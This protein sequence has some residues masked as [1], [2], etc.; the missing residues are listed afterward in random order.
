MKDALH[1]ICIDHECAGC[2]RVIRG[3]S[4][5]RHA[6]CCDLMQ[7]QLPLS[8]PKIVSTSLQ[9][10]SIER[11]ASGSFYVVPKEPLMAQFS[12]MEVRA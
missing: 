8:K 6:A 5:F 7:R 9:K 4:F 12:A 2:G 3:P 11:R 1:Q 10:W